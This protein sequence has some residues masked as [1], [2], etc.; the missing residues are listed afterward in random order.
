MFPPLWERAYLSTLS[1]ISRLTFTSPTTPAATLLQQMGG[2]ERVLGSQSQLSLSRAD[3]QQSPFLEIRECCC[4]FSPLPLAVSADPCRDLAVCFPVAHLAGSRPW[5][6]TCRAVAAS[7]EKPWLTSS[8][9]SYRKAEGQQEQQDKRT[10]QRQRGS[11][12]QGAT[13]LRT[14]MAST[15]PTSTL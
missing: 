14:W 15:W 12:W 6:G 11:S 13:K 10:G 3:Y 5:R 4:C 8:F 1:T 7:S 9:L 2:T